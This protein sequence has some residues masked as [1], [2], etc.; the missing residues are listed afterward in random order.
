L[1][2]QALRIHEAIDR[3]Q[4]EVAAH[5]DHLQS[6]IDQ[7]ITERNEAEVLLAEA[8]TFYSN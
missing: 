1:D 6:V 5:R 2:R 3:H 8:R 7:L 4:E